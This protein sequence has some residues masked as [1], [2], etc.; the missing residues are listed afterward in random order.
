MP[1]SALLAAPNGPDVLIRPPE[2]VA[3]DRAVPIA[4]DEDATATGLVTPAVA[5]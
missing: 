1:R 5:G 2:I 3:A 4:L